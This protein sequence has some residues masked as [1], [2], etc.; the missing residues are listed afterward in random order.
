[1]I[2]CEH[3]IISVTL[4]GVAR[5]T[6]MQCTLYCTALYMYC[7]STIDDLYLWLITAWRIFRTQTQRKIKYFVGFADR[8]E[9]RWIDRQRLCRDKVETLRLLYM[10]ATDRLGST[11]DLSNCYRWRWI[12]ANDVQRPRFSKVLSV[13]QTATTDPDWWCRPWFFTCLRAVSDVSVPRRFRGGKDLL[14]HIWIRINPA[15]H[16]RVKWVL[17][18]FI[19]CTICVSS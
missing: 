17:N 7:T 1:M 9:W 10:T 6:K 15:E 8:K 19:M 4:R 12:E 5:E 18:I 16:T 2:L 13:G 14:V 11:R 3:N